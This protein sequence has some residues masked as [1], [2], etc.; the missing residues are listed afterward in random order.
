MPKAPAVA[1][2]RIDALLNDWK[3]RD[4]Q[5]SAGYMN[6]KSD[7]RGYIG[8]RIRSIVYEYCIWMVNYRFIRDL[9]ETGYRITNEV[10]SFNTRLA[11]KMP[12]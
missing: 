2:P 5:C 8:P 6:V 10:A 9:N 12:L 4:S 3:E 1:V 11:T 7:P